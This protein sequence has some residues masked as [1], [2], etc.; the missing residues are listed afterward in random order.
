[1][2]FS[3]TRSMLRLV[4]SDYQLDLKNCQQLNANNSHFIFLF[5]YSTKVRAAFCYTSAYAKLSIIKIITRTKIC[6]QFG[7]LAL[8]LWCI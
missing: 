6:F 4:D 8:L 2:N 7:L 3:V 1:M 5:I